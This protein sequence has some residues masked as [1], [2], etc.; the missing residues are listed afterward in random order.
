MKLR[1]IGKSMK[2]PPIDS[3]TVDST[4]GTKPLISPC[5]TRPPFLIRH[6]S[7]TNADRRTRRHARARNFHQL[8][9]MDLL[10]YFI[11][12]DERVVVGW[13]RGRPVENRDFDSTQNWFLLLT[14]WRM[15]SLYRKPVG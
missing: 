15:T 3:A 14:L 2:S 4:A 12:S 7:S 1:V 10:L 11:R 8:Q 13:F 6:G 5:G 9:E